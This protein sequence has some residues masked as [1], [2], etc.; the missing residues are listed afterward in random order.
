MLCLLTS[1]AVRIGTELDLHRCITKMPHDKRECYDRTRLYYM[2]YLCDHHCSLSHGRPPLT[3]DFHSLKNPRDFLQSKYS[4]QADR[5]LI[6]QIELWSISSRVFDVFGADIENPI[7]SH[8]S[9]EVKRLSDAYDQW[10][11]EWQDV[12]SFDDDK[13][14]IP[15]KMFQLY[16]HS[17]RLYLFS[18]VFRGPAQGENLSTGF[19]QGVSTFAQRALE[20]ALSI[21]RC[22]VGNESEP[23][24]WLERL[25]LYFGT[26]TAFAS[27]CLVRLSSY[28]PVISN[29]NTNEVRG[30]LR[31]LASRLQSSLALEHSTHPLLSIAGS[32]GQLSSD[33]SD[34][35]HDQ[36]F[37]DFDFNSF[38]NDGMNM[39]LFGDSYGCTSF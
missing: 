22:I 5:K 6:S 11:D 16:T 8:R 4:T 26:M 13:N 33:Q 14:H 21:V 9:A 3:R 17:A 15:K 39:G 19:E 23:S 12:F 35:N 24:S 28:Q 27:V 7:A 20:S 36:F 31:Q 34:A 25:P 32:L 10:Y 29:M 37:A 38:T 2:L 1:E 30:L 18:H